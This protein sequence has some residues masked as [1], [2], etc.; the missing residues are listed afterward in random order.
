MSFFTSAPFF[1]GA[2]HILL[3]ENNLQAYTY[4]TPRNPA[5]TLTSQLGQN[6]ELGER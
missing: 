3:C 2:L 6:V 4:P 5:L 1:L